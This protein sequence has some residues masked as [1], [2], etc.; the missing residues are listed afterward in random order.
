MARHVIADMQ[1]CQAMQGNDSTLADAGTY[2]I[3]LA[4]TF[5]TAAIQDADG[6]P[7]TVPPDV[8]ADWSV[9]YSVCQPDQVPTSICQS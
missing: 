3:R 5:T 7:P 1:V 2:L 8:I 4:H 6:T 9:R